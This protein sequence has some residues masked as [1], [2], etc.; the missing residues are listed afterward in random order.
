MG[1]TKGG[2]RSRDLTDHSKQVRMVHRAVPVFAL[3]QVGSVQDPGHHE[4][5]V[6][7]KGVDG[8]GSSGVPGLNQKVSGG[9]FR[10]KG[11]GQ[12]VR[13]LL[14]HPEQRQQD[15][16]VDSKQRDLEHGHDQ[17]LDRTGF[18]QNCSKGNEDGTGA[19]IS[20]DHTE[21]KKEIN[22]IAVKG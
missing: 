7:S 19:E 12:I 13:W 1:K 8:H 21:K 2:G 6:G 5:K 4:A 15:E 9:V 11:E 17:Q 3:V 14:S 10:N 18:T 20:I 16:L 22:I